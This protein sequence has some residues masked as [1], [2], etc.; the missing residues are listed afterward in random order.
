MLGEKRVLMVA[1][2]ASA[3]QQLIIGL[4]AHKWQAFA[5]IAMGSLG[6]LALSRQRSRRNRV[7][8]R[9]CLC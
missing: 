1:L 7:V 5:G 8:H 6:E 2:A 3:G 9:F 4:A